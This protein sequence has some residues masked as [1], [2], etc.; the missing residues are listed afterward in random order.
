[1]T[2]YVDQAVWKLAARLPDCDID[3]LRLYA[4]LALSKGV[5]TSARDVHDA[6]A[7]WRTT[8]KADHPSIVPF[9]RLSLAVQKLDDP[10]VEAIQGVAAEI[11][12][13]D[14]APDGA[15]WYAHLDGQCGPEC[16]ER[17]GPSGISVEET[18]RP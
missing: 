13:A 18:D 16:Q 6:W 12:A 10:Y 3:L 9:A 4:L 14:R 5:N 17:G 1:M 11:H 15:P 7:L 8:T 2:N